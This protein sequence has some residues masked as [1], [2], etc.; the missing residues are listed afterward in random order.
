MSHAES[1]ALPQPVCP[2]SSFCMLADHTDP[3]IILNAEPSLLE[4]QVLQRTDG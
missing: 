2:A 3:M 1:A 4:P